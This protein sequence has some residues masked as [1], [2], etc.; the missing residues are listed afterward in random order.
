MRT[1]RLQTTPAQTVGP[2]HA[3]ALPWADGP[4]AVAEGAPGAFWITG[5]VRDGAGEPVADAVVE[6]WQADP[7]GRFD[8]PDD[9]RGPVRRP[10]FRGFARSGTAPSGEFRLLT[11]KPG[12]LPF[13]DGR[14]QAP[15]L[16]VSVFCRGLL[17][18]LV[19]RIYFPD[20]PANAEDPV[21][22]S[23]PD[24]AARATLVAVAQPG[25]YRFDIHLQG[26]RET[27]FFDL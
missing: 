8:H 16:D 20:E 17:V 13:G 3:V 1:G 12:P 14:A 24:P 19:T 18:R 11:V 9:P 26:E 10:G 22:A 4:H 25:G 6:T 2:F 5:T 27:V 7:D 15:H 21:L 23:I